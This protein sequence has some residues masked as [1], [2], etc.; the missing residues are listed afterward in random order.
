M[1]VSIKQ[2][3]ILILIGLILLAVFRTNQTGNLKNVGLLVSESV[4]DQVWG[5]RGY[6]GLLEI[7]SKYDINIYYR[8]YIN[9]DELVENAI[10]EL[11]SL[12]V[13][14]IIGN[15]NEYSAIFNELSPK[16]PDIQ[17]ISL[18]GE[19]L[20]KNTTSLSFNGY[21]MGYFGGMVAAEMSKSEILGIIAA[22]E[23]QPEIE[24]FIDGAKYQN[25]NVVVQVKYVE[26]WN[27]EEIA[28]QY[29]EQLV[30]QGV[31]V[32]YPAGNGFNVPVIQAVKASGLYV[33]GY[34]SDQLVQGENTVLTST[35][36]HVDQL[37]VAAAEQ[38]DRGELQSGKISFDFQEGVITLGEFSPLVP[39]EFQN[40]IR[41]AVDKYKKTG[42]LPS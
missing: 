30:E 32:F 29:T 24:G 7:G 35:V 40:Q 1:K 38:F 20:N 5:T 13:N 34:V 8:E 23:W 31:D 42:K 9:S 16:Y 33:I 3:T 19:A 39:K 12:G 14:V 25:P 37:Y 17:F 27:D 2:V 26:D 28:L 4:S 18:N 21:A 15:G 10:E 36:Q 6:K 41:R 22:Y 11:E